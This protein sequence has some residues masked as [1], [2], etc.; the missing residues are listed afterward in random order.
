MYISRTETWFALATACLIEIK[1]QKE[2]TMKPYPLLACLSLASVAFAD[3][4]THT[5]NYTYDLDVN[6]DVYPRLRFPGF[7]DMNGQRTLTRVDVRVQNEISATIAIEN[8]N[9]TPLAGWTLDGQHLVLTG[10]E[11]EDPQ[12]FGPFAFMGGLFIDPFDGTLAPNDGNEGSGPDFLARSLSATI[13]STL[14]MD[15]SYLDFFNGGGEIVAVAGP[16]TEFFLEGA[17]V[18]D[19]TLSIGDATVTFTDLAQNGSMSLIY[20]FTSVPEPAFLGMAAS[21][22]VV[23]LR[24]RARG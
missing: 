5:I 8:M 3:T 12:T 17:Q 22:A 24:R 6:G 2:Q 7:D 9:D 10:F 23:L 15:A 18:F 20:T 16:F 1:H 4:Q 21:T 19:P 13:D 11:R 14:D